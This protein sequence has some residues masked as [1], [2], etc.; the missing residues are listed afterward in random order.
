M[1]SSKPVING[2]GG[3]FP[4]RRKSRR[5]QDPDVLAQPAVLRLQ[6]EDL[7]GLLAADSVALAGVDLGLDRPA[8]HRLLPDADLLRDRC[9]GRRQIRILP[10]MLTHQAYR[11]GLQLQIDLLGTLHILLE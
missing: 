3:R 1:A 5:L 7:L 2:Y 8:P 4:P 6:P 10:T 9:R 11:P